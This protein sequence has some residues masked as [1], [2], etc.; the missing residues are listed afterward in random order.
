MLDLFRYSCSEVAAYLGAS[1]THLNE[2]QKSTAYDW[3]AIVQNKDKDFTQSDGNT[4]GV[5]TP[6]QCLFFNGGYHSL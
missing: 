2:Y 1:Q 4:L 5:S 3:S 6:F